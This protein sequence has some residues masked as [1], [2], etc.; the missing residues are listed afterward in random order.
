M[1][2]YVVS[3]KIVPPRQDRTKPKSISQ[4]DEPMLQIASD[5]FEFELLKCEL[6]KELFVA[7]LLRDDRLAA[8]LHYPRV[9]RH[10]AKREH[11]VL[12][13]M[14]HV[15]NGILILAAW[16]AGEQLMGEVERCLVVTDM[17]E[18]GLRIDVLFGV[19]S[20]Y[21]GREDLGGG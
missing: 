19:M 6:V 3:D 10:S 21:K 9:D 12:S 1:F 20:G 2:K 11:A 18:Q 7:R 14:K 15:V 17:L 8:D 5:F 16:L 4:L 13:L